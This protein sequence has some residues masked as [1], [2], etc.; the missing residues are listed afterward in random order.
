[1]NHDAIKSLVLN[2]AEE[3]KHS[4]GSDFRLVLKEIN[5]LGD[6]SVDD[7]FEKNKVKFLFSLKKGK[8]KYKI[9]T[10]VNREFLENS[11]SCIN[12][13]D[14]KKSFKISVLAFWEVLGKKKELF[15]YYTELFQEND[16]SLFKNSES[17]DIF[18][19]NCEGLR[20]KLVPSCDI[21]SFF[22]IFLLSL[23][24][25]TI[26]QLI[27]HLGWDESISLRNSLIEHIAS[28]ECFKNA[29]DSSTDSESEEHNV[30]KKVNRRY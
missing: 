29:D 7:R 13:K 21:I 25:F 11:K 8:E 15:E 3:Y 12:N 10:Y 1:M 5:Q 28:E 17:H 24:R 20:D 16:I 14:I 27:R 23:F 9:S 4:L 30:K 22:D 2:T 26:P 19:S 6:I 18:F